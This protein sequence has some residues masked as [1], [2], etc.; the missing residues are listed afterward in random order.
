[1]DM[2]DNYKEYAI[3]VKQLF[4][5][6]IELET[7]LFAVARRDFSCSIHIQFTFVHAVVVVVT[8]VGPSRIALPVFLIAFVTLSA[9]QPSLVTTLTTLVS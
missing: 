4:E 9:L 5:F 3:D 6:W 2:M 7:S 8:V 1:M